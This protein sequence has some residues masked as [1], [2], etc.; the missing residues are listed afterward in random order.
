MVEK[1]NDW[2]IKPNRDYAFGLAI[3]LVLASPEV[4]KKYGDYFKEVD[5]DEVKPSDPR[6]PMLINKVTTIYNIVRT[7][8]EKYAEALAKIAAPMVKTRDDVKAVVALREQ[9]TELEE[10]VEELQD[11]D[12]D[13]AAEIEQLENEIAKKEEIIDGMK[14]ELKEKGMRVLDGKDLPD[15]V[16]S[17][18]DRIKE[19]VPLMASV[20]A[21]L[22]NEAITEEDRKALAEQLCALDDERR[23]HWDAIDAYLEDY[24]TTLTEEKKFEYSEDPVVRGMQMAN[25]IK[26]LKENI[27]R[28]EESIQRHVESK[29][30]ALEE[31]SR[32]KLELFVSELN[33]LNGV[34]GEP[35]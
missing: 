31:K 9:V 11:S 3:F 14:A 17:K 15:S 21:D 2:L 23:S 13:K 7:N 32:K 10:R 19:I 6:F 25:R 27:R 20:H 35:E 22:R 4:R 16:R 26:R 8:P 30:V 34:I 5:P 12:D 1:I 24:D 18:Y 29:K 33:E 28:T